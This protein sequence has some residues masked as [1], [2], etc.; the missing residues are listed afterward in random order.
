MGRSYKGLM[1]YNGSNPRRCHGLRVACL[2][3]GDT[4]SIVESWCKA[5]GATVGCRLRG[6]EVLA[7]RLLSNICHPFLGVG[8]ERFGNRNQV[9]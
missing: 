4:P 5:R 8:F 6:F 7:V 1:F 2:F 3:G 9:V